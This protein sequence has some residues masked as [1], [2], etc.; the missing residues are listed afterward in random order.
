MFT[1]KSLD[2]I[3]IQ[4]QDIDASTR[5]YA[6]VLGLKRMS[7]ESAWGA[8]PVMM[9][10]EANNGI[11]LFPSD[12]RPKINGLMHFAFLVSMDDF[13]TAQEHL[14][15]SKI[16]FQFQDHSATHSIYM[17]DPDGYEVELTAYV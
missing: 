1:V 15:Q 4:V 11:A 16:P 2:H 9:F 17:T 7:F 6:D 12:G 5:W 3:A 10:S 8:Y 13:K 14:Q